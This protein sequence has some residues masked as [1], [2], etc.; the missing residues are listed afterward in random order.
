[1][2]PSNIQ[3]K[4]HER[5][6]W[7]AAD[8][9]IRFYNKNYWILM[10]ALFPLILLMVG[11]SLTFFNTRSFSGNVSYSTFFLWW[12]LPLID[13]FVILHLSDELFGERKNFKQIYK[14]FFSFNHLKILLPWLTYRRFHPQRSFLM[15]VDLLEQVKG[16]RRS[17]RV[18]S[19]SKSSNS[20]PFLLTSAFSLATFCFMCSLLGFLVLMIPDDGNPEKLETLANF[21]IENQDLQSGLWLG[22]YSLA[23]LL[24]EPFYAAAGFMIYINRRV[25]SEGWDLWIQ[26]KEIRNR[27]GS[28]GKILSLGIVILGLL[29]PSFILNAKK[30]NQNSEPQRRIIKNKKFK[31]IKK[32]KEKKRKGNSKSKKNSK[33]KIQ[34]EVIDP[35]NPPSKESEF[36]ETEEIQTRVNENEINL[37]EKEKE[38]EKYKKKWAIPSEKTLEELK[39]EYQVL[40]SKGES[41]ELIE[42]S[43]EIANKILS[44][45]KYQYDKEIKKRKRIDSEKDSGFQKWLKKILKWLFEKGENDRRMERKSSP[46][47]IGAAL[48]GLSYLLMGVVL[49]LLGAGIVYL[50]KD[51]EF[52]QLKENPKYKK[53]V[54]PQSLFGLDLS[55]PRTPKDFLF[56]SENLWKKE[57]YRESLAEF[58]KGV[59][60]FILPQF[61]IRLESSLTEKEC[62]AFVERELP[63]Y[64][65]DFEL[66]TNLW[67]NKAYAHL[68]PKGE[69]YFV[70]LDLWKKQILSEKIVEEVSSSQNPRRMES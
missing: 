26:F 56:L 18:R 67:I 39:N 57:K 29:N 66:L 49:V 59:L 51:V 37:V 45:E 6:D 3:I 62:Q 35:T 34:E 40:E 14:R 36:F 4:L 48:S 24:I 65:E 12:C 64:K 58:Y 23:I 10:R 19:I 15:G 50:L 20:V 5:R 43:K 22:S 46:S 68:E 38:K 52:G 13:A 32:S 27:Y 53:I 11:L 63:H 61:Q 17:Q 31:K 47:G 69:N 41:L 54:Q 7:E 42:K 44:Q 21:F 8:L 2:N 30:N 70:V 9:G 1:M 55:D 25:S 60:K 16:K 28:L 33:N